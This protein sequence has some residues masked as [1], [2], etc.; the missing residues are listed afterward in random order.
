MSVRE[1]TPDDLPE[2]LGLVHALADHQRSGD[3]VEATT[4][5][6]RAALFPTD[7]APTV[8]C[9]VAEHEGTV[10]GIAIWFRNFSTWTGR[11]GIWMEDL[12]VLPEMRGRGV[13]KELLGSL[14]RVC[15]AEGYTRL[16][17][18]VSNWNESSIGFYRSLG[19]GSMEDETTYRLD[20]EALASLGTPVAAA[21]S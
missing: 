6:F 21:R 13:G 17:W 18:T 7:A 4:E 19:A 10:V 2:I 1:A 14:A 8:F 5:H 12:F 20:G 11:H 9:H 3:R 15:A 16:E